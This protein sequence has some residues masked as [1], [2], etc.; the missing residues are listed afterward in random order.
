MG[1]SPARQANGDPVP[2]TVIQTQINDNKVTKI[3][4]RV[5][6]EKFNPIKL[7]NPDLQHEAYEALDILAFD[8]RNGVKKDYDVSGIPSYASDNVT[9]NGKWIYVEEFGNEKKEC[10]FDRDSQHL[11]EKEFIKGSLRCNVTLYSSPAVVIF[12]DMVI[13]GTKN[14]GGN[15]QHFEL[16]VHRT[17]LRRE[18][19]GWSAEDGI[20]RPLVK[21]LEDILNFTTGVY[22]FNFDNATYTID[23]KKKAMINTHTAFA[24]TLISL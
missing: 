24:R 16:V 5:L 21:E 4:H 14:E 6:S 12:K 22:T 7:N 23:L 13:R 19:Y 9:L 18:I 17:P 20:I 10:A 11:I 8:P 15:R 1:C 3:D 2:V